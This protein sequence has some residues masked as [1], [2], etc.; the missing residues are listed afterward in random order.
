MNFQQLTTCSSGRLRFLLVHLSVPSGLRILPRDIYLR[1]SQETVRCYKGWRIS[2]LSLRLSGRHFWRKKGKR[3]FPQTVS[4]ILCSLWQKIQ[5]N[6]P[7]RGAGNFGSTE[8]MSYFLFSLSLHDDSK[9]AIFT[10]AARGHF[11]MPASL[12]VFAS[13]VKS[14]RQVADR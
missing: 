9:L 11:G 6:L 2:S 14:L 5:Y 4:G 3:I 12:S 13:L 7:V 10:D 8:K 1:S